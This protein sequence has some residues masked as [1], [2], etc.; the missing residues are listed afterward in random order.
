MVQAEAFNGM[1]ITLCDEKTEA[2]WVS[3][4]A[5]IKD[6]KLTIEGQDLGEA[7]KEFFGSDEYEYYYFFDKDNTNKL[8]QELSETGNHPISEFQQRFSGLTAC[9]DLREF[10]E[11]REIK[12]R[13]ESWT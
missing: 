3:V 12:Y 10:C 8:F 7:P 1:E 6:G 4:R 9:R 13:F 5:Y 11:K 2:L